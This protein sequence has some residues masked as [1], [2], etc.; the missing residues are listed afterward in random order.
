MELR[1]LNLV[2]VGR[3]ESPT[4]EGNLEKQ[5]DHGMDLLHTQRSFYRPEEDRG[6]G[7]L[8]AEQIST[9][10]QNEYGRFMIIL[11]K[12]REGRSIL[13]IPEA[14]LNAG[15]CDIAFKIKN[16]IKCPPK[17]GECQEMLK[18]YRKVN[19]LLRPLGKQR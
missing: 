5:Q 6:D 13:I 1:K 4:D 15:L 18:P 2:S 12:N 10:K 9:R 3:K 17:A 14:V 16:F 11:S 19:G 8:Y 7:K